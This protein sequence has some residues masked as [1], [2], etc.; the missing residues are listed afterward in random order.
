MLPLKIYE[1][2]TPKYLTLPTIIS[3]PLIP[4]DT[5]PHSIIHIFRQEFISPFFLIS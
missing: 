4:L 1:K 2:F 3:I 5:L